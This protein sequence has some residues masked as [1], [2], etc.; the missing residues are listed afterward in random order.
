MERTHERASESSG[1]PVATYRQLGRPLEV[2]GVGTGSQHA[3]HAA[4]HTIALASGK[5]AKYEAPLLPKSRTPAL[6]GQRSLKK[7]R[8][9]LDCFNN[10]FYRIGPGGYKLQLAPGSEVHELEESHA[11]HLMLPCSRFNGEH[12]PRE[13]QETMLGT[14]VD[15]LAP[16]PA[17]SL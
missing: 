8:V 16:A 10:K 1:R 14:I 9:L 12:D 13:I 6:L 2:G 15:E 7:M 17:A 4:S 11:G 3:T 5:E